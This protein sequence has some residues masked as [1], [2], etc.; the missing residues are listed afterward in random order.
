M[1]LITATL[2]HA[3][4]DDLVSALR[5]TRAS[6]LTATEVRLHSSAGE[7]LTY[8]GSDMP[9]ATVRTKVEIVVE[10]E[11][12]EDVLRALVALGSQARDDDGIA[13]VVPVT[14]AYRIRTGDWEGDLR[15]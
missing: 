15:Q 11:G 13:F 4:V 5:G 2:R 10:D 12:V 7:R 14:D 1:K 6:G 9:V 3:I 8:R